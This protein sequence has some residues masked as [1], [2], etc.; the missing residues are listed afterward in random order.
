MYSASARRYSSK[1]I[2]RPPRVAGSVRWRKLQN[3][4]TNARSYVPR[5]TSRCA[6]PFAIA[7]SVFGL[8]KSVCWQNAEVR[9]RRVV[10]SMRSTCS[11]RERRSTTREKST[12]CISA[13]LF[14]QRIRTSH[15]S[16][17]S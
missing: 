10:R 9:V 11:P 4:S 15:R 5:S 3:R 2:G 8:K 6:M 14:P 12:G 13:G 16:R 7:R 1:L 17:S